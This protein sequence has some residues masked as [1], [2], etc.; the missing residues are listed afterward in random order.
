MSNKPRIFTAIWLILSQLGGFVLLIAPVTVLL[1][2]A[3]LTMA[4]GGVMW[5]MA[6]SCGSILIPIILGIGSWVAF[7]RGGN[8]TAA[9]LS[10][11]FLL[12]GIV[13]YMGMEWYTL[14]GN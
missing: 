14:Y 5:L 8:K 6:M 13:L 2:L 9:V 10:G 7:I 3:M 12:L 1:A 4:G 11:G